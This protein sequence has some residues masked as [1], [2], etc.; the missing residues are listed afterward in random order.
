MV[1][2]HVSL[3]CCFLA[4]RFH[5]P[6]R[7][8]QTIH[9]MIA[10]FNADC[11]SVVPAQGT[12]GASGDLAPLSHLALGL[13]GEGKMWD[14]Q[15]GAIGD[16]GAI[17]IAAGCEHVELQAK[18]G[19]AMI[20]GTQLITSLGAESLCRSENVIKCANVACALTLEALEGTVKAYHPLIHTA[21]PHP[22]QGDIA[23]HIRSLLQPNDPSEIARQGH[24]KVQDA[25]SLRCAPQVHGIVLDT[26]RFVRGVIQTEMNSATD[27]P[28]VFT[29]GD[30]ARYGLPDTGPNAVATAFD[31]ARDAGRGSQGEGEAAASS[32]L[33]RA[34]A[35]ATGG[36]AAG[37]EASDEVT[38]LRKE[39]ES[40]RAQKAAEKAGGAYT[41]FKKPNQTMYV[42]DGG[43]VI[44]GG[45]FHGEYPAKALDFL[46]IGTSELA[47]ISE[48][49]IERL[50]NPSLSGLP[51]FL[52]EDG[53]LNSGFMIAHCTAA[54]MVSENKVRV[55]REQ[56]KGRARNKARARLR[57]GRGRGQG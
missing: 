19:L 10:A 12:V 7:S 13:M 57:I 30:S 28:M 53:G 48:R 38:A 11:I 29:D 15:T 26:S 31:T 17:L 4:A 39:I 47:C 14:P 18:E 22:G 44:S 8:T 52:V 54:A 45:N 50:C 55:G 27:N 51:A 3:T 21:R 25:Y 5:C 24:Q 20:N 33:L 16:A 49:R 41:F 2:R 43:F 23:G 42:G 32:E 1:C 56:G 40:L 37:A 34:G 9:R 35:G 46:A 6:L 36:G